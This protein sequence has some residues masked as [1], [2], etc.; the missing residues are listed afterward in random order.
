M[1]Y[2]LG[3]WISSWNFAIKR[4]LYSIIATTWNGT[5]IINK[6][7]TVNT[8]WLTQCRISRFK[9]YF[10]QKL[11]LTTNHNFHILLKPVS[12]CLLQMFSCI[13]S[14]L[15]DAN[16]VK[17]EIIRRQ[18]DANS[19]TYTWW[20]SKLFL[21]LFQITPKRVQIEWTYHRTHTI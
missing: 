3:S 20:N 18:S 10:R 11:L 19:C 9:K 2:W 13:L 4:L 6:L 8:I 7:Q 5:Y 15:T 1:T 12:H 14:K 21:G 16:L 17:W